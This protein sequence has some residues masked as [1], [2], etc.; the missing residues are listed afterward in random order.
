MALD[1]TGKMLWLSLEWRSNEETYIV[2]PVGCSDVWSLETFFTPTQRKL[3]VKLIKVDPPQSLPVTVFA[4]ADEDRILR[5]LEFEVDSWAEFD[6]G[7]VKGLLYRHNNNDVNNAATQADVASPPR[8]NEGVRLASSTGQEFLVP[9]YL[10]ISK[11]P[12]FEAM[13]GQETPEAGEKTI[14]FDEF[15]TDIVRSFVQFVQQDTVTDLRGKEEKLCQLAYRYHLPH[16]FA[17]CEHLLIQKIDPD[18]SNVTFSFELKNVSE[19]IN[20]NGLEVLSPVVYVRNLPWKL[21]VFTTNQQSQI[22]LSCHLYCQEKSKG[23]SCCCEFDIRMLSWRSE[24][25]VGK[26]SGKALFSQDSKSA[27]WNNFVSL[28]YLSNPDNGFIENDTL[29]FEVSISAEPPQGLKIDHRKVCE[30]IGRLA[31]KFN[32]ARLHDITAK[33]LS[34]CEY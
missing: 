28:R 31:L 21:R 29:I 32:S 20:Q 26:T 33:I 9:R 5:C 15:D 25:T 10:L 18:H 16:L 1:A 11:S 13:L 23:W 8:K 27:G 3:R 34:N 30:D 7:V 17:L 2:S 22:Y 4:L 19:F 6:Y 12:V 24:R 14:R